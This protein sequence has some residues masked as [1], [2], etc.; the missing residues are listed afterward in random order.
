MEVGA[1][2]LVF[3]TD[4]RELGDDGA[5]LGGNGNYA[6]DRGA[7]E[8]NDRAFPSSHGL[9]R[10]RGEILDQ[11]GVQLEA[12]PDLGKDFCQEREGGRPLG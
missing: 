6:R 10:V 8:G 5:G 11:V 7:K 9:E 4:I 2:L 12:V 3:L 1:E